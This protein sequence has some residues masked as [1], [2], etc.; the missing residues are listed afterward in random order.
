MHLR[1]S[2]RVPSITPHLAADLASRIDARVTCVPWES[3]TGYALRHRPMPSAHLARLLDALGPLA[4]E[5]V[6]DAGIVDADAELAIGWEEDDL[7]SVSAC[8][9]VEDLDLSSDVGTIVCSEFGMTVQSEATGYCGRR[10]RF[11][12]EESVPAGARDALAWWLWHRRGVMLRPRVLPMVNPGSLQL[13][14][15]AGKGDW[16]RRIEVSVES[17]DPEAARMMCERL[18]ALG[19]ARLS[20]EPACPAEPEPRREPAGEGLT[21]LP[22]IETHRAA[23]G[24]RVLPGALGGDECGGMLQRVCYSMESLL[25]ELGVDA[26]RYPLTVMP[27]QEWGDRRLRIVLPVRAARSGVLR[28]G[29]GPH[30]QRFDVEIRSDDPRVA[31]RLAHRLRALG[32]TRVHTAP[33]GEARM[34]G[35]RLQ[36]GAAAR[37]ESI[38]EGLLAAL[39]AEMADIGVVEGLGLRVDEGLGA[40]DERV[41]IQLP[42]E[43]ATDGR[44]LTEIADPGRFSVKIVA[45]DPAL[46]Q[47]LADELAAA[48]WHVV[49]GETHEEQRLPVIRVGGAPDVLL[50]PLAE[51]LG[52]I[53]G[54]KVRIERSWCPEDHDV[55]L[56][57]P[58]PPKDSKAAAAA[59]P[60]TADVDAL[61]LGRARRAAARSCFIEREPTRVRIGEV[62]LPRVAGTPH[63]LVPQASAFAHYVIDAPTAAT[64]EYLAQGVLLRE[65]V[66]LEG[67]TSTSKT[68]SVFFL[69]SLLNQPVVRLNL[70]GQTDTAELVGRYAP[71]EQGW[72]WQDGLLVQAMRHGHWVILDE[73]NLA[74]PQVIERL[75]SVLEAEPGLVLS[76]GDGSVIGAGGSPVNAAWRVFATQNPATYAGRIALS[77]AARDRWRAC[78]QV[79]SPTRAEYLVMLRRAVFGEQPA[80]RVRG[81]AYGGERVEPA[82]ATLATLPGIGG[83][84]ESL[85][86][87]H[88]SIGTASAAAAGSPSAVGGARE[89]ANA[90]ATRRAL[91][92][93]L[94][95]LDW[96][97]RETAL[98]TTAD[99]EEALRDALHRYY[100]GRV[101]GAE[102]AA[103]L[104]L[105]EAAG[106]APRE[107]GVAA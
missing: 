88:A 89:R 12:V 95:Y 49:E 83:M 70:N 46:W 65:P 86:T 5:C 39:R 23:R 55:F 37:E 38:V 94:G 62:T 35:Y 75:N 102:Q 26:S 90:G 98:R 82:L 45:P 68:S 80:I 64:L 17:D 71:S 8:L 41:L 67:E 52:G 4:P 61:F 104:Q 30:P 43:G 100:L 66:L 29:A 14:L 105:V 73:L 27:Y 33:L 78:L 87:L 72:R 7:M 48:G 16:L 42:V 3:G 10:P 24:F 54:R 101:G 6:E 69:A 31:R 25:N 15:P 63:P 106:L 20:V 34:E 84:L 92:A 91:L 53:L 47:G 32:Y 59:G 50:A 44:L 79:P 93:V 1:L 99:V 22:L 97:A 81:H 58:S 56:M 21:D 76:E 103:V 11:D 57:L 77:P 13:R 74:E 85:A 2:S 28:P 51:R 19:F 18:A 60:S 107:W 96:R 9:V 40:G 36:W